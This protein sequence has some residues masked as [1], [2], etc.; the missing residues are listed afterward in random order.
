[1]TL[2]TDIENYLGCPEGI[3]GM[4]LIQRG[5]EQAERFGA[6]ISHGIV[7]HAAVEQR[8]FE[9][10]LADGNVI[11]TRA[12]IVATGASARWVGAENQDELMGYGLS[13][14]ATC[15]GAFHRG[16]DVIVIGGG[17]SAMEEAL[18]LTKFAESVTIVHRR[19]ALRASQILSKRTHDHDKIRFRWNTEL[20]EIHGTQETG[21]IGA[22]LISHSDGHPKAKHRDSV[23]VETKQ[24]DIGGIFYGVGHTPNTGFLEATP[25]NLDDDGYLVI[26]GET[27]TETPVAGVFGAGDV[28]D[29]KYHQAITAA[30]TRSMA[31]PD[32][33][34]WLDA[35][36]ANATS[37]SCAESQPAD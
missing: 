5:K 16:D 9:L 22:T 3:G 26:Q 29:P 14:C 27:T 1:L 31:A 33:E 11:E 35:Q 30:G 34:E 10:E 23:E 19:D 15:D 13:T 37:Q 2:T 24:V 21:V 18:F 12:L 20:L 7:E 8:P 25:V 17:D 4:E 32:A 36:T 28:I 6:E